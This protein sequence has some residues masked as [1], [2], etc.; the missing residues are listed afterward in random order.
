MACTSPVLA[1]V[2]LNT[3]VQMPNAL[4]GCSSADAMSSRGQS[5][6]YPCSM[7]GSPNCPSTVGFVCKHLAL[8]SVM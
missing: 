1:L 7:S 8:L 2:P 4:D 5:V 6:W 3:N